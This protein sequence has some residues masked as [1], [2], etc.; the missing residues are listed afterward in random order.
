MYPRGRPQSRQRLR[1]R[2]LNFGGLRSLTFFAIVDMVI[3][4]GGPRAA[5]QLARKG[6]PSNFSNRRPSPSVLAVVTTDTFIPRD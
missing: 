5:R 4:H 6:M 1:T 3:C 2:T